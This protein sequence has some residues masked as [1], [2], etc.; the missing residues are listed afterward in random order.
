LSSKKC[1]KRKGKGKRGEKVVKNHNY[2]IHLGP[3]SNET[4]LPKLEYVNN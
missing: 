1:P 3:I 4:T 2:K